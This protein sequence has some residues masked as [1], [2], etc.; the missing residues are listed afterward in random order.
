M[1][2]IKPVTRSVAERALAAITRKFAADIEDGAA[3]VL[4]EAWGWSQDSDH[5]AIL[6]EEG[7]YEW[8]LD[9]WDGQPVEGVFL[10]PIT[11]WALGVYPDL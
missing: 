10:E 11:S 4:V 7:P 9:A 3:P 1:P 5:W 2:D 8:A 6:W